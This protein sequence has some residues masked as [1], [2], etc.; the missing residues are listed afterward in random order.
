VKKRGGRKS[1]IETS[2]QLVENL[3]AVLRDHTAGDP[4]REDVKW[5]NLSRRQI[6][7][8]LKELGTPAGK[9]VV[10][11][12]LYEHG[13]RRRKPQKKRT[14]GQHADRNAQFEKIAKLKREALDAGTPV[15]SIDTKK[16]EMLGNFHRDGITDAVEPTIVNDH[17]FASCSNS[18]VIPH[19]IYDVGKNEASLHLNSNCDTTEF[20]CKSIERW[21]HEQGQHD[22]ASADEVLTKC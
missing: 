1:L 21:W 8:R 12:L 11:R 6:S 9:N 13:Y 16:K 2:P 22:Y 17:D 5:T 4:M 10:S 15:I 19:G 18:K 3:G 20:C 7:R 14:M